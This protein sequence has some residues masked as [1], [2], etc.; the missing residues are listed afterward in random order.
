V[1]TSEVE[2]ANLLYR[3]AELIDGGDL[4]GMAA[5]FEHA[6]IKFRTETTDAAGLLKMFGNGVILY[7]NGTPRTKH[8][9]TNPIIEV[10]EQAGTA[11]CRSYYTVIQQVEGSA[12]QPVAAGRYHDRF[13]RVA[14]VWR[15]SFRDYSYGDLFGDMSRHFRGLDRDIGA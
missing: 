10:D 15:F 3:Y 1:A 8:V 2:I 13:E 7:P 4:E 9:T 12:L 5:L 14:D 6:E 11:T